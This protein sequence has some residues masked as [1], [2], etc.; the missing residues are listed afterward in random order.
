[1]KKNY[2]LRAAVLL[3][4]LCTLTAGIFVGTGT[5]A[6]YIAAGTGDAEARVAKF[7]VKI[8]N[9]TG[10]SG[11]ETELAQLVSGG[12]PL[13]LGVGTTASVFNS[14]FKTTYATDDPGYS[15]ANSV[16]SADTGY[17]VA[18]GTTNA[19]TTESFKIWN[20]S[21]V[22]VKIKVE[23]IE[24]PSIGGT[25]VPLQ[26]KIGGTWSAIPTLS[27]SPIVLVNDVTLAPN[28]EFT[29]TGVTVP[30]IEWRWLFTGPDTI[31]STDR[32]TMD[33]ADAFDTALGIAA[34]T[35]AATPGFTIK[36]TA[37]QID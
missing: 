2:F 36:I 6:K 13:E 5:M 20:E 14:I 1:M 3:M 8:I 9:S 10:I 37:T 17:V 4:V 29:D 32:N 11:T 31:Y 16:E 21:E 22:A 28:Q 19:G 34:Q 23:V 12:G 33:A 27:S 7:S 25:A 24:A 30:M 35:N 15:G 26:V 18:P